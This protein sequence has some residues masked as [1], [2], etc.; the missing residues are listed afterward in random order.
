ME[1]PQMISLQRQND[2]F[3]MDH[4]LASKQFRKF[5]LE[6][7][8]YCCLY[9]NISLVSDMG[10]ACGRKMQREVYQGNVNG[11]TSSLPQP[12]LQP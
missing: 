12:L 1:K 10:S 8:N 11:L 4:I 2:S 3:F 7:I 6:K 5:E 9:L